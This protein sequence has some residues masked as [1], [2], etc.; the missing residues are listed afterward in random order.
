MSITDRL[1]S[2]AVQLER[3]HPVNEQKLQ[4][5]QQQVANNKEQ[6]RRLEQAIEEASA[7]LARANTRLAQ[8]N[9]QLVGHLSRTSP[10]KMAEKPVE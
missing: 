2:I 6:L 9:S 4:T 3:L 10:L 1:D 7:Q 8:I 5:L